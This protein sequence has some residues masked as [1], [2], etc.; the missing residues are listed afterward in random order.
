MPFKLQIT[1]TSNN[2]DNIILTN[3]LTIEKIKIKYNWI[4]NASVKNCVIGEDDYGLVWYMGEWICGEWENGTWYSGI[5]RDGVWKNGKWYSYLLDRAMTI[6]NR[7]VIL[8][9]SRIYSEF[10]SGQWLNGEFYDGIF[11]YERDMTS[12]GITYN[13]I[14]GKTFTCSYWLNGKFYNGIFKNSVW[15]NGIFYYGEMLNSYWINGKFYS[16]TFKFH[17]PNGLSNWWNGTWYGGDFIEGSWQ[18]GTFDQ[19]NPN[20]KSRFGLANESDSQTLWWNGNFANGEFH[21]GLNLDS[22]GNTIPSLYNWKTQFRGGNF[23]GGKWY[24]GHFMSGIFS[25]GYWYGGIFHTVTGSTYRENCIWKNGKWYNGLWINGVFYNGHFYDGLWIDGRFISGYMSTNNTENPLEIQSLAISA[26]P[27]SVTAYTATYVTSSTALLNGR[28]INNGGANILDRSICWSSSNNIPTISDDYINDG[29]GMGNI[30]IYVNNLTAN[31][32]YYYRVYARNFT[33]ETYSN[34]INFVTLETT[35]T[36]PQVTTELNGTIGSSYFVANGIMRFSDDPISEYGF[37]WATGSTPLISGI[38]TDIYQGQMCSE[39]DLIDGTPFQMIVSGITGETTYNYLAYAV[40]IL[41]IGSGITRQITTISDTPPALPTVMISNIAPFSTYAVVTGRVTNDGNDP[42]TSMGVCWALTSNP[43]TS[44][45][46]T[47]LTGNT[48]EFITIANSLSAD[49]TYN[50]RAYAINSVGT[51]YSS[52]E[53]FDT[54][55]AETVP[56]VLLVDVVAT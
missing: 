26:I 53:T 32:P 37:I 22:S 9:K 10:R 47:T 41:G 16:G 31:T 23:I 42:L 29:G 30:N 49:T 5:W 46:K 6:S 56:T 7:F 24:G 39:G 52:N 12:T 4:L 43:T 19:I 15:F 45:P 36:T 8:D 27:P 33:G 25:N 40:N 17:N 2:L 35:G 54:K 34:I 51:A 13:N 28:I 18:N 38:T 44:D 3:N 14:T 11:G 50:I 21:S 55:P 48:D 20:I 1:N